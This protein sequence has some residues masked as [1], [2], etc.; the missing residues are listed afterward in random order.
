MLPR[1]SA[2]VVGQTINIIPPTLAQPC[3]EYAIDR[4]G[5]GPRIL[6]KLT[7]DILGQVRDRSLLRL[8]SR[9]AGRIRTLTD[10][11]AFRELGRTQS[12]REFGEYQRCKRNRC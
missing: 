7:Y 10:V 3:Y 6:C 8:D 11:P 2:T 1:M 5:P 12:E 9:W 4:Q